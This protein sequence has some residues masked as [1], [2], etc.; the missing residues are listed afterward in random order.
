MFRGFFHFILIWLIF[1]SSLGFAIYQLQ[2]PGFLAEQARD[3]RL[4]E[5]VAG[6]IDNLT[7]S[8]ES[9]IKLPF[10][11]EE[12]KEILVKAI[13]ADTFYKELNDASNAY[14]A[15]LIGREET[16]N[17]QFNLTTPKQNL[18]NAL[19]DK[20]LAKY[21][22]LP[23][24]DAAG[25]KGWRADNGLPDCQL[26]SSNVQSNDVERL[27]RVQAQQITKDLPEQI[28]AK[29]TP[30]LIEIRTHLTRS[31]QIVKTIWLVT[32]AFLLLYLILF[33]TR[34]F[35]SLATTL[36]IAGALE[37]GFSLIGWEWLRRNITDLIANGDQLTSSI[38][39]D[40]TA[41]LVEVLKTVMGN[42]SIITLSAGGLCLILGVFF[43]FRRVKEEPS[44]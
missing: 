41:T 12:T 33:R 24:C 40:L 17:Y 44:R 14:L 34:G 37:I 43:R 11:Q 20:L 21:R 7:K 25:L 2:K 35:L 6:Q 5:R 27:F 16:V 38:V 26:S 36:I 9:D 3:V 15:Y 4:Y 31:Y 13:D 18:E 29:T 30:K 19:T 22:A 42:L 32:L 1:L 10:T 28:Q 8:G 23:T 39:G